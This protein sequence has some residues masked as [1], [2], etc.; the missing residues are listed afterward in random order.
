MLLIRGVWVENE[1]SGT[2]ENENAMLRNAGSKH[3]NITIA[4][5]SDAAE[6]CLSSVVQSSHLLHNREQ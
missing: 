2:K 1:H 6:W 3:K 5:A 4:M